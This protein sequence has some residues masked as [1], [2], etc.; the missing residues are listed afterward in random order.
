[1]ASR[2]LFGELEHRQVRHSEHQ[3]AF[4]LGANR[5]DDRRMR[6]PDHQRPEAKRVVDVLVAV[7]IPHAGA[8]RPID[9]DGIRLEKTEITFDAKGHRPPPA[10]NQ[11]A[12]A[13]RALA[14]AID[15]ARHAE[16]YVTVQRGGSGPAA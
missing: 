5:A 2:E 15:L 6:M 14:V 3:P 1:M 12:R 8:E 13:G 10:F 9:E 16:C 4:R 7:D 11:R